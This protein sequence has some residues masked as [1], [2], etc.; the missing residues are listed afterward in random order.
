MNLN[1][2]YAMNDFRKNLSNDPGEYFFNN[3][4]FY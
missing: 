4:F 3:K 2:Y 1:E